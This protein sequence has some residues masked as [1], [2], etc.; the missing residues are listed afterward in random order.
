LLR[1]RDLWLRWTAKEAAFW[2]RLHLP[3]SFVVVSRRFSE[4]RATIYFAAVGLAVSLLLLTFSV[5]MCVYITET[6]LLKQFAVQ[7][8]NGAPASISAKDAKNHVG[9]EAVVSGTILE[10]FVSRQNTNVYLYLDSDMENAKFAVIWPGTNDPPV[11]ALQKLIFTGDTISVSGRI[12]TEK[13]V[14]EIVVSSWA[15][16]NR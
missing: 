9:E 14:P 1:R 10:I 11:K 6:R 4:S 7:V 8:P 16:I 2:S 5:G 12:T 3:D 13:R 15:Q